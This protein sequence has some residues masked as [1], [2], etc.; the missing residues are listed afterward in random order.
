MSNKANLGFVHLY[1]KQVKNRPFALLFSIGTPC[2][3]QKIGISKKNCYSHQVSTWIDRTVFWEWQ[4][5]RQYNWKGENEGGEEDD[6][7]DC[8]LEEEKKEEEKHSTYLEETFKWIF[9]NKTFDMSEKNLSEI[10][11]KINE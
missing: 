9:E 7:K 5:R 3:R 2:D 8:N 10:Q 1:G 6:D 11:K 4:F